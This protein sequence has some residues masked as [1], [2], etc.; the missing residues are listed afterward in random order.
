M[1][2]QNQNFT[3][4]LNYKYENRLLYFPDLWNYVQ[5]YGAIFVDFGIFAYLWGG[6]FVD[7]LL[8]SFEKK[9]TFL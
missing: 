6:K 2:T 7:A 8:F 1:L 4:K 5:F 3:L 9:L